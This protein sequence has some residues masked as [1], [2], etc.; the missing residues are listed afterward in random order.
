MLA[1]TGQQHHDAEDNYR[2]HA[3]ALADIERMRSE[4]QGL[5]RSIDAAN[6]DLAPQR[7][8]LARTGAHLKATLLHHV[9]QRRKHLAEHERA[10]RSL[11]DDAARTDDR[12]QRLLST[13]DTER[14][15]TTRFATM[16]D[17]AAR[18]A[19]RLREQGVLEIEAAGEDA[20]RQACLEC[21]I[22][23]REG[24]ARLDAGL[25]RDRG[26]APGRARS[27]ASR[28]CERPRTEQT[29]DGGHRRRHA[30][31]RA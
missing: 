19:E 21:R 8:H 7:D 30:F 1:D 13:R 9:E 25:E 3:A 12:R 24:R 15:E 4:A 31:G 28:D 26:P 16:L 18:A 6:A 29:A 5:Q 10:C 23:L 2:L 22:T 20:S 11:E 14:E 27:R 17:T